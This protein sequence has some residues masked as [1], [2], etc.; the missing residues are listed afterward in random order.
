MKAWRT[1]TPAVRR[2]VIEAMLRQP[3]RLHVLLDELEAGRIKPSDLDATRTRQLL[4]H[5]RPEIRARARKLLQDNVPA[6]RRQ[7]LEQYQSALTRSGDG[8]RGRQVFKDQC[9]TC[10]RVAAV[11]VDV[12]PDIADSRTKTP[13]QLLLDILNPNAAIDSNYMNYVVSTKS[14]KVLTG[15]LAAETAS[16]I[17]LRRAENQT[18]VVL[19]AEIEEIQST[20]Q[21]LMPEGLEKT[22]TVDQ[23]ADLL[24]FLKNWRYLDGTVPLGKP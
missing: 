3:D 10:H 11:G 13:E 14:G 22:I 2:E 17:T 7:V 1:Y 19:R 20:G 23:M 8:G 24:V 16:S 6:D 15:M 21:S 4:K 18:E 12:G 5:G 9:A